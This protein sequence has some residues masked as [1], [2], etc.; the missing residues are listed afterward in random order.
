M[1]KPS[2]AK[3]V[4]D[5]CLDCSGGSPLEVTLCPIVQCP[6]WLFRIGSNAG[7]SYLKRV[8]RAIRVHPDILDL[9]L[10]N[11]MSEGDAEKYRALSGVF[12]QE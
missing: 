9:W 5:K 11:G 7:K 6:L 4:K 3:A 1:R 2:R 10:V 12:E 8:C